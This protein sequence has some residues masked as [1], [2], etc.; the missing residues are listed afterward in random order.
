MELDGTPKTL[1][2]TLGRGLSQNRNAVMLRLPKPSRTVT[3]RASTM[4]RQG[5]GSELARCLPTPA[6]GVIQDRLLRLAWVYKPRSL[7]RD[8]VVLQGSRSTV[9]LASCPTFPRIGFSA[10]ELHSRRL[11]S[12]PISSPIPELSI[13]GRPLGFESPLLRSEDPCGVVPVGLPT[14]MTLLACGYEACC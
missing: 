8:L 1:L 2:H 7:A 9:K 4:R 6:M 10:Q 12:I 13:A 5:M 3:C 14:A 11:E